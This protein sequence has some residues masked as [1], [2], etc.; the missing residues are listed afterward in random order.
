MMKNGIPLIFGVFLFCA[1]SLNVPQLADSYETIDTCTLCHESDDLHVKPGHSNCTQCHATDDSGI[2]RFT[3]EP[4]VCIVCHP[5]SGPGTCNLVGAHG[6]SEC[7][8]CHGVDCPDITTTTT[9]PEEHEDGGMV[10]EALCLLC[11]EMGSPVSPTD[12]T[13]HD[14]HSDC[15]QCHVGGKKRGTVTADKCVECH[16]AGN[17]GTCNLAAAAGHGSTCIACHSYDCPDITTTTSVPVDHW[18]TGAVNETVCLICHEMGSPIN[19]T[20]GTLHGDHNDC[21][22]CHVG[23]K[24]RGT[25]M[26]DKCMK[27]HP[28]DEPGKC[29][30]A[31]LHGS[32]CLNCHSDCADGTTTTTIPEDHWDGGAVNTELCLLCHGKL[33]DPFTAPTGTLHGNHGKC[34]QCHEGLPEKGTVTADK[35]IE[36]HLPDDPGLCS[37]VNDH[38]LDCLK[39]HSNCEVEITT[40]TT[41]MQIPLPSLVVTPGTLLRSR[42]IML[43]ALMLIEGDDTNFAFFFSNPVYEPAG[44]V[45]PLPAL[46][47]G[48][49]IMV[50]PILVNPAWLAGTDVTQTVTVTVDEASDTIEINMLA[51]PFDRLNSFEQ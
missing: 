2:I 16:P 7:L 41:T 10:N 30:L 4:A 46:V 33:G 18:G 43:P 23:G 6:G 8:S 35:C 12:G 32:S 28:S 24:K 45:F 17:E 26:A 25:V 21:D 11:H 14:D 44:A 48:C 5:L 15:D 49:E 38:G 20:A 34:A 47:L 1:F 3:T 29:G 37:L 22:Q 40:T 51:E 39:C 19:L 27:C 13:L 36:C 9:V 31:D 42:W 50:Q